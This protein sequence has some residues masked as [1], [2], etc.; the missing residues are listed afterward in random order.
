MAVFANLNGTRYKDVLPADWRDK[1][2][3]YIRDRK[4]NSDVIDVLPLIISD[5][6]Q[7]K[8]RVF[9]VGDDGVA[10]PNVFNE[11]FEDE[12][13]LFLE[14][15][16]YSYIDIPTGA[17]S[18]RDVLKTD[19]K[20]DENHESKVNSAWKKPTLVLNFSSDHA[21]KLVLKAKNDLNF[22]HEFNV[23]F[24]S[25]SRLVDIVKS[26]R[27]RVG[28]E[29]SKSPK[30][31]EEIRSEVEAKMVHGV[32]YEA[33]CKQCL[34]K[35]ISSKY[36]GET[37]R[38]LCSRIKEH[39]RK[40]NVCANG[41]QASAISEHSVKVHGEQPNFKNWTFKILNFTERTQDR[42]TLEAL[43]IHRIKP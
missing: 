4:W 26:C 17:K 11:Q 8:I 21:K 29:A 9:T 22:S 37:G 28:G 5:M 19:D 2:E 33:S 12:L 27:S 18:M 20:C 31:G 43:N 39:C 34:T 42:K 38:D 1:L 6:L 13:N 41:V 23:V 16:H 32:V 36:V 3:V 14:K 40:V 25:A 15:G 30:V 24:K 10:R 7:K 35:G